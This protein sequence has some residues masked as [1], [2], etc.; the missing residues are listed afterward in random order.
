VPKGQAYDF[1]PLK[2]L[3]E[4]EVKKES[5][6]TRTALFTPATGKRFR[7]AGFSIYSTAETVVQLED[8]E[9]VFYVFG[10]AAKANVVV[11]WLPSGYL[12]VAPG[13]KLQYK[14]LNTA[15]FSGTFYGIEDVS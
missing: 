8:A 3:A 6:T 14:T 5:E 9:T 11:N 4:V 12:S 2:N 13:N 15:K 7:L 10:I 1:E